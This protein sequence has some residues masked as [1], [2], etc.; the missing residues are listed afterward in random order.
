[1]SP[2]V[3]PLGFS[4]RVNVNSVYYRKMGNFLDVALGAL[5]SN[6]GKDLGTYLKGEV[7]EAISPVT[8][9][10]ER[11]E[12]KLDLLIMAVERVEKLLIAAQP[13]FKAI[14]KLPFLK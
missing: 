6:D 11:L 4:F 14:N 10:V 2:L 1:M 9:R 8:D 7:E 12:K 5:D 13:L 3:N